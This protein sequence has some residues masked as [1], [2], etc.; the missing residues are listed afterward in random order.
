M[1]RLAVYGN[2]PSVRRDNL[3]GDV[4]AESQTAGLLSRRCPLEALENPGL[5]LHGD[6]DALILHADH[7][8]VLARFH[9]QQHGLSVP[10]LEGIGQQVVEHLL[11]PQAISEEDQGPGGEL[12][13]NLRVERAGRGLEPLVHLPGD[14]R[15]VHRAHFQLEPPVGDAGHVQ[16]RVEQ[17][18]QAAELAQG[19]GEPLVERGFGDGVGL[20]PRGEKEGPFQ[21]EAQ[22]GEGGLQLVGRNGQKVIAHADG[23]LGP[24]LKPQERFDV[25][26]QLLLLE[27][28]GPVGVRAVGQP[29]DAVLSRDGDGG[30][31]RDEQALG[32][33][34]ASQAPADLVAIDVWHLD[35]QQDQIRQLGGEH[36]GFLSRAGFQH[37]IARQIQH[38]AHEVARGG[39][40]IDVED[41]GLRLG[42]G[43]VV[44]RCCHGGGSRL[45]SLVTPLSKGNPQEPFPGM[46]RAVNCPGCWILSRVRGSGR[47]PGPQLL[48]QRRGHGG[49]SQVPSRRHLLSVEVA[50]RG[51]HQGKLLRKGHILLA[52]ARV[53]VRVEHLQP[54][55]PRLRQRGD[56][57]AVHLRGA[58]VGQGGGAA[59]GADE[60][61]GVRPVQPVAVHPGRTPASEEP[62]ECLLRVHAPAFF[63][64]DPGQVGPSQVGASRQGVDLLHPHWEA[65]LAHLL[66]HLLHPL[67][68]LGAQRVRELG[69]AGILWPQEV[70][71]DVGLFAQHEGGQLDARHQLHAV[72][73][74]RGLRR[75]K[76]RHRVVVRDR[77]HRHPRRGGQ[78]QQLLRGVLAVARGGVGVQIDHG[79]LQGTEE[80]LPPF[81]LKPGAGPIPG[82]TGQE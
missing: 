10:I 68:A 4:E 49:G 31:V 17:L 76:P 2:G 26:E 39:M 32:L 6:A 44:A 30:Q 59:R 16:Q 58:R 57:P 37:L 7:G 64:Q 38:A 45:R 82:P 52:H 53:V 70:P 11:H 15:Q 72:V 33:L 12:E 27:G 54:R 77:E 22:R 20:G 35:V 5:V 14:V 69:D 74:R 79:M 18:L 46:E 47:G 43:F 34:A 8:H 66:H 65:E 19:G 67:L 62:V 41:D 42:S 29:S 61:D 36:Q 23:V 81:Y 73:G 1:S 21:V 80:K 56:L 55:E 24:A 40:V 25:G 75:R 50:A 51:R 3:P 28:G 78:R 48:E 13:L 63:H 71:Q 9:A 60:L